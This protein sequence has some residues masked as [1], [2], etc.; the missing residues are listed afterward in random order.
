[1]TETKAL[2]HSPGDAQDDGLDTMVQALLDREE[3]RLLVSV[4]AASDG[5]DEWR[6]LVAEP[7]FVRRSSV[8]ARGAPLHRIDQRTAWQ[9][10]PRGLYDPRTLALAALEAVVS[11]QEM[12][13][14]ATTEEVIHFLASLA[15]S[16]APER[17]A[18]E[19]LAVARFVLRE[20]L[21]DAQDGEEFDVSY[22]DYR[23]GHSRVTLSLRLLEEGF[24][25]HNQAVLRATTP[26]I[27]LLL[28]G[29]EH[30]L[31]D[32]QAAKD[33]MLRRQVSTRR[34]GRA[35]ESAAES[36][37]LSLMYC[38][39]VRAVLEETERDVR[40]VDWGKDVSDLLTAS[41]AHSNPHS[42]NGLNP[43]SPAVKRLHLAHLEVASEI[44][45]EIPNGS[46][47]TERALRY[48]AAGRRPSAVA[49]TRF[50]RG[51]PRPAAPPPLPVRL[52]P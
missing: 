10:F 42:P 51:R 35:E 16:A 8:L 27:N 33:L 37:K 9:R 7:G 44:A 36:L 14:E 19:H 34:W 38:E 12:E 52:T 2:P 45:N 39:R 30:D 22:S 47:R 29:L 32:V 20:L 15:A 18:A 1:M 17:N 3:R 26:A 5:V 21:N 23:E 43:T 50:S 24:G 49:C 6:A 48:S 25:R 41:R 11:Q 4:P 46:T 13:A 31:E 28:S 40:A